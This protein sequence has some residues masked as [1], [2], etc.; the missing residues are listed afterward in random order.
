MEVMAAVSVADIP[1]VATGAA[2][3]VVDGSGTDA[4][5][6]RV[7]NRPAAIEPGAATGSVRLAFVGPQKYAAGTA[8]S[9]A[10]DGEQHRG[11]VVPLSALVHDG[12]ETAVFV[13][14]GGKAHRK[15]IETGVADA[16]R[17]EVTTGLKAGDAVI[18]QG[19]AG[20]P[21]EAAISVGKTPAEGA[22]EQ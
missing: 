15:L 1:R 11:L 7:I 14:E 10:I 6:L 8:V 3:R 19:Q 9:V 18:V 5:K 20:L 12:D 13:A 4:P 2:A 21:D 17:V 22:K 16:E